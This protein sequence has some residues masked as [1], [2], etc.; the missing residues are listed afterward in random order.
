MTGTQ[1]NRHQ[2][3][4]KQKYKCIRSENSKFSFIIV[5]Y[6]TYYLLESGRAE[7]EVL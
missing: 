5:H 7:K 4:Q 3:N 1:D 6:S 2:S